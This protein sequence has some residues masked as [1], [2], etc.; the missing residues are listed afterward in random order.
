M[1]LCHGARTFNLSSPVSPKVSG[2]PQAGPAMPEL[3]EVQT[4]VT[5]LQP[6]VVGKLI[7][8]VV[9]RRTDIVTPAGIDLVKLLSGRRIKDVSRRGK[10]IV[11]LLD[12]GNRF[13]VHLGMTGRLTV[14]APEAEVMLHTHMELELDKQ[15][16]RF[17]DPRR[18]GGVWWLGRDELHD[19]GM[20][21]EPLGLR[22][23]ILFRNLHRT[24]RAVKSALLDQA[25]VAGLGNIYVDEALFAA[26]IHPLTRGCDLTLSDVG[27]L[28]R[29]IKATLRRA[30]RHRGS[31]LRDY[32]DA[33]GVSGSFQKLHRVYDRAGKPC[34]KCRTL[35]ERIVLGGRSTHFCPKCQGS[36]AGV[37]SR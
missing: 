17:R 28:N 3:P 18:F 14:E 37:T 21:P 34:W 26:G 33:D 24:S 19:A 32:R 16:I 2:F 30:L 27:K 12:D 25:V 36:V 31:T 5:T 1:S 11:F 4:V 13:Y 29:A 23:A 6:R 20:G 8:R 10:R 7:R 9:L 15:N 22:P 35:I